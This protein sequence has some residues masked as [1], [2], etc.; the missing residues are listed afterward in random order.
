MYLGA[1]LAHTGATLPLET[2]LLNSVKNFLEKLDEKDPLPWRDAVRHLTAIQKQLGSRD[3]QYSMIL[4][5]SKAKLSALEVG[6]KYEALAAAC[7]AVTDS[8]ME[9]APSSEALTSLSA[10]WSELEPALRESPP[11]K[12]VQSTKEALEHLLQQLVWILKLGYVPE[13]KQH[14]EHTT[15]MLHLIEEMNAASRRS[16]HPAHPSSA[17]LLYSN[18][19]T[20]HS[21]RGTVFGC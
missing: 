5:E 18:S 4:D 13:H 2:A 15:T 6:A 19:E 16:G 17:T 9:Q 1:K 21:L 12:V 7:A 14:L 20:N 11:E 10:A 3:A 8:K